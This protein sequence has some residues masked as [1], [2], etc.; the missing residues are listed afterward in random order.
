M[1]H[2]GYL[3][4]FDSKYDKKSVQNDYL[5]TILG[6]L[7]RYRM[8]ALPGLA[9]MILI[10]LGQLAGPFILKQIIDVAVPKENTGLL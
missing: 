1:R 9:V 8:L 3:R 7:S 2:S 4:I 10:A 5:R 6:Y